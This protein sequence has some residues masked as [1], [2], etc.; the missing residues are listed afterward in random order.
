MNHHLCVA[1][2]EIL[3]FFV[4]RAKEC[5]GVVCTTEWAMAIWHVEFFVCMKVVWC[6]NDGDNKV[7]MVL[8]QPNDFL[9]SAH[10]TVIV[11]IPARPFANSETVLNDP[12]EVSRGYPKSPFS[13]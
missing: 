6:S 2:K 9:L 8:A 1:T 4:E 11:A 10:A 13:A 7:E 12:S 5:I 3:K